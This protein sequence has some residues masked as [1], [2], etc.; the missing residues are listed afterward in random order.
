MLSREATF[1][2]TLPPLVLQ[3]GQNE[4]H[5]GRDHQDSPQGEG[6]HQLRGQRHS[7]DTR[8]FPGTAKSPSGSLTQLCSLSSCPTQWRWP[9]IKYDL[10]LGQRTK[11]ALPCAASRNLNSLACPIIH[12]CRTAHLTGPGTTLALQPHPLRRKIYLPM[13]FLFYLSVIQVSL[14]IVHQTGCTCSYANV[15]Q[16]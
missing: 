5:P 2:V 8:C 1:Q 9:A 3:E 13:V 7:Q 15:K 4:E 11:L 6:C 10:T 14:P 16:H 12:Q